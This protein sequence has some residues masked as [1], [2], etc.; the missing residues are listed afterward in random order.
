MFSGVSFIN[1]FFFE[2]SAMH[3]GQPA[4]PG[5][6][7]GL[8]NSGIS[9][10]PSNHIRIDSQNI[11]FFGQNS[12]PNRAFAACWEPFSRIFGWLAENT[13]DSP[14]MNIEKPQETG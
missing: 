2:Q 14:Y 12:K 13:T 5:P 4:S 7:P 1:H 6:Y 3:F 8:P 11:G 9:K 10:S